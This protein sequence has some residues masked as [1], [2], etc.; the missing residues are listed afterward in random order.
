MIV[1]TNVLQNP[2]KSVYFRVINTRYDVRAQEKTQGQNKLGNKQ[3]AGLIYQA[4]TY[5]TYTY[6][7]VYIAI[8]IACMC[9]AYVRAGAACSDNTTYTYILVQRM[10][11]NIW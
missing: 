8:Y 4:S 3:L 10:Y 11:L 7:Y 2:I 9:W 6:T 1:S 5:Y